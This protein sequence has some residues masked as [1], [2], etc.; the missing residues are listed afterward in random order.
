MFKF[1]ERDRQLSVD[2]L[3]FVLEDESIVIEVTHLVHKH[4]VCPRCGRRSLGRVGSTSVRFTREIEMTDFSS[5]DN[6]L[7]AR[8]SVFQ[9]LTEHRISGWRQGFLVVE[10]TPD[11]SH[12]KA[13]YH[14]LVIIGATRNYAQVVGLKVEQE[15]K[16]CGYVHFR[17]PKQG[18]EMPLECWDG[19]D[20]FMIEEL[21]G[22]YVVTESVRSIIEH[23]NFSG[24]KLTPLA[25][26]EDP[27]QQPLIPARYRPKKN[28]K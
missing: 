18:L 6:G 24:V 27:L 9:R 15:C 3:F 23:Y 10:T 7:I 22:L 12:L 11:V 1:T 17:R 20:I 16:L 8:E 2:E 14:E 13:D 4:I 19:S 5:T 28:D 25:E 21:P 26:W